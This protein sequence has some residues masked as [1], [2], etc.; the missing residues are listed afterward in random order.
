[1]ITN[2]KLINYTVCCTG[3]SR[4]CF[5]EIK[6]SHTFVFS[7]NPELVFS[8]FSGRG[9]GRIMQVLLKVNHVTRDIILIPV[10]IYQF[11]TSFFL[12]VRFS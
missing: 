8:Y 10:I 4:L 9:V 3:E 1:M 2:N 6:I 12:P 11:T 5:K 7:L